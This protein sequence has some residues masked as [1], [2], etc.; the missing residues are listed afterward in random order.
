MESRG[1]EHQLPEIDGL[2]AQDR[3]ARIIEPRLAVAHHLHDPVSGR[4]LLPTVGHDDPDR[5][6]DRSSRHQQCRD[7]VKQGTDL[8]PAEHQHRQ[9]SGF[10]EEREDALCRQRRTEHVSDEA[11]IGR[12]VRAELELHDDPRRHS[13]GE[14]DGEQLGPEPGCGLVD[15]LPSRQIHGFEVDQHH[16][17]ADGDRREQVMKHDGQGELNP[18]EQDDIQFHDRHRC[19]C[20]AQQCMSSPPAAS[21]DV[22]T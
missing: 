10:E 18:R 17:H 19:A 22:R 8:V 13:H 3:V 5:R 4:S 6:E 12:P 21:S 14:G 11:G 15:R 16:S 1:V 7:E 9:E 2:S 20:R